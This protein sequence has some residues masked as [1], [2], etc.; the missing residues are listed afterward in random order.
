MA[1]SV[2]QKLLGEAEILHKESQQE[3]AGRQEQDFVKEGIQPAKVGGFL[4]RQAA[5]K[6]QECYAG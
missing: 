1:L 6:T 3:K 2:L 5:E 4:M